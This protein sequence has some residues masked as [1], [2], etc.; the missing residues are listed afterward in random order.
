MTLLLN[1]VR[2]G[3][4][5]PSLRVAP[6]GRP[7]PLADDAVDVAA[8]AGLELDEWQAETLADAMRLAPGSDR[9]AAREVGVVVARQNGKG[10]ILEV[11]QIGGMF[12]LGERLQVHSAHEFKTCYEHFRRVKDLIENCDLLREQVKIIRTGAGDQAIE[13]KNGC[14]IRFI[15]RSRSSGRGFTADT[16]YLDEAFKLDDATIGALL[17]AL[18]ARPNSQ[19]WYTSSAPHADSPVLHRA[20]ERA[21]GGSD[22]RLFFVEWG[23]EPGT[24]PLDREAWARANPAM[25]IRIDVEDIAGEQR[26]MSPDEFARERLGIP[27]DPEGDRAQVIAPEVWEA[28][29]DPASFIAV[30]DCWA[31]AVSPDRKWAAFGIAGRTAD[32]RVH[33]ECI[34]RRAADA[35]DRASGTDWVMAKAA[36]VYAIK[37]LPLRI[38]KGAA[39]D[40][41]AAR[42]REAGVEI[43]E[44]SGIEA[45]QATGQFVDLANS[46]ELVH[47]DQPW[48]NR[49]LRIAENRIGPDGAMRWDPRKS[50]VDISPLVAVTVALGGVPVTT[51]EPNIYVWQGGGKK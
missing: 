39:E 20:R 37:R 49:S 6:V 4:A 30:N 34:D 48:L 17:P 42:L 31:L 23:N 13:L 12:V 5:Q 10:G 38:L 51:P 27:D 43:L 7:N 15:A 19:V 14:R 29:A 21:I 24:D 16:V 36:E 32:G 18:S 44:V 46:G 47:L 40:A 26:A 1:D 8:I 25:G 11:R 22:P 41:F 28:L 9:W 2:L 50:A 35:P 33:V 3:R 45:G